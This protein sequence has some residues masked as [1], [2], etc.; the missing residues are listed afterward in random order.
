MRIGMVGT[1]VV[2]L[3]ACSNGPDG[4]AARGAGAQGAATTTGATGATGGAGGHGGGA[5]A[6]AGGAGGSGGMAPAPPF[7]VYLDPAGDDGND[8]LDTGHAI[9]TLNRAHEIV[10]L[11]APDRDVEVRIRYGTYTAQT[12]KWTYYHPAHTIAFL[13]LDYVDGGGIDSIEGRPLFDGKGASG[14]FSLSASKGEKTNLQFYYLHI[15]NY[16]GTAIQFAGNRNNFDGGWNGGNR[17][18]GVFFEHFGSKYGSGTGYGAV[19]L[20]NSIEN[21]IV[22]SHF[23]DLENATSQALLHSV[24]LAHGSRKNTIT[25]NQ[26]EVDSGDPIRARDYSNEN[27]VTKNTFQQTGVVAFYSD[28]FC[29]GAACTKSTAECPSWKN[30]FKDNELICGYSGSDISVFSYIKGATYVPAGCTNHFAD[31]WKRLSTGGNNKHCP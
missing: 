11:A 22:N 16:T 29:E 20:V 30:E 7:T 3:L 31:G 28:W 18:Y 27:V 6:G 13:P 12:V 23:V 25:S 15:K 9:K 10:A 17:I 26:F 2:T 24:Y 19:D 14:F 5:D 8:G 1:L 21:E 4:D